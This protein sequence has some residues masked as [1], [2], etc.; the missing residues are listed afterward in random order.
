MRVNT[1]YSTKE[2]VTDQGQRMELRYYLIQDIRPVMK[3]LRRRNEENVVARLLTDDRITY[4][5]RIVKREDGQEE[6]ECLP[7]LSSSMERVESLLRQM[8]Y[9]MVTPSVAMEVADDWGSMDS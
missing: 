9:G 1:L 4:G 2:I 6:Q 8:S 7:G 3:P 5:I